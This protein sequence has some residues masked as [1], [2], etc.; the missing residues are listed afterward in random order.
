M[1][2]NLFK[3]GG[4]VIGLGIGK[5]IMIAILHHKDKKSGAVVSDQQS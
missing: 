4:F 2:S 5:L 3:L 1:R